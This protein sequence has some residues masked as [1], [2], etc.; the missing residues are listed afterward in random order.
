MAR[1]S[2][3]RDDLLFY[4]HDPAASRSH[5]TFVFFNALTGTT[6]HWQTASEPLRQAGHGV[7]VWNYRGQPSTRFAEELHL[8]QQTIVDDALQLLDETKPV[9]PVFV[10]LSIGGLFAAW[11]VL[12]G[13][14]CHSLVL[15]NTLRRDG[16]RLR[17]INDAVH[18]M[19]KI[20]GAEL[21]RDIMT[22]LILNEDSLETLRADCLDETAGYQPLA[23]GSGTL[24]LLSDARSADWGLPYESLKLPVLVVTGAH[25]RVF[26]DTVDIDRIIERIPNV[27]RLEFEDAGHMIPVEQPHRLADALLSFV[28]GI[29]P[30]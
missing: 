11:V 21:V 16:P 22:P 15:L 9:N 27:Q 8:G 26:R 13:S 2:I 5:C 1:L 25:D 10:G 28:S 12:T 4:R 3:G 17:W 24:R 20:G 30:G 6:D 29:S 7:L 14:S 23:T 19:A 18:Q